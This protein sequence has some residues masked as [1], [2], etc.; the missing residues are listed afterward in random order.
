V[1]ER[2]LRTFWSL[3]VRE[4]R[5]LDDVVAMQFYR[6]TLS[7]LPSHQNENPV[8]RE[9]MYQYDSAL[10]SYQR[11]LR[12][13]AS[14]FPLVGRPAPARSAE[15]SNDRPRAQLGSQPWYDLRAGAA[16]TRTWLEFANDPTAKT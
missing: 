3:L 14:L 10:G 5:G 11:S 16:I 8:K 1:R 7:S 9:L 13:I 4:T 15:F 2:R 6:G 12:P